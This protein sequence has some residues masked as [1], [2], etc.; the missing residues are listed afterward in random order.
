MV[1]LEIVSGCLG[2]PHSRRARASVWSQRL[3]R[4]DSQLA[5]CFPLLLGVMLRTLAL[6]VSWSGVLVRE[7]RLVLGTVFPLG[8]IMGGV[9]DDF[10]LGVFMS[11]TLSRDPRKLLR[12]SGLLFMEADL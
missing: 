6:S 1:E 4:L 10:E 12:F 9:F 7:S 2:E 3:R 8:R 11:L 5:S